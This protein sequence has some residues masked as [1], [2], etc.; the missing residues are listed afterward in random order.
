MRRRGRH[1]ART[2]HLSRLAKQAQDLSAWTSGRRCHQPVPSSSPECL[3]HSLEHRPLKASRLRHRQADPSQAPRVGQIGDLDLDFPAPQITR[4][5]RHRRNTCLGEKAV[6]LRPCCWFVLRKVERVH[7]PPPLPAVV[8]WIVGFVVDIAG[9]WDVPPP[10]AGDWHRIDV[11]RV[12]R[13]VF[14]QAPR[15]PVRPCDSR[16]SPRGRWAS[17]V[18][19]AR[20]A[21]AAIRGCSRVG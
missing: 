3:S 14:L 8:G 17:H 19:A 20:W 15:S 18:P 1:R 13:P 5:A 2:D 7:N 9:A 11:H 21:F 4:H 10:H 12:R 6:P 16:P